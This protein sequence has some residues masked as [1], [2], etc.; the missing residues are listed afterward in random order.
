MRIQFQATVEDFVDVHERAI[1]RSRLVRSWH[2]EGAVVTALACGLLTSIV[3]FILTYVMWPLVPALMW[4][5]GSGLITGAIAGNQHRQKVR[6]RLYSYYQEVFGE[7]Q[8][9]PCEVELGDAGLMVKQLGTQI[10]FEWPNVEEMRETEDAVE[11]YMYER[12]AVLVKK[13][14]FAS[15]EE[16]QQFLDVA[17]QHLMLSRTSSNWLHAD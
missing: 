6:Q 4:S 12:G 8:S 7:R 1:A 15:V 17:R 3:V 5:I 13:R 14:Y 2:R 10:M 11:F 16:L 9:L